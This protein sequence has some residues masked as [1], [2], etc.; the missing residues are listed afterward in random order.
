[1]I[2]TVT[3]NPSVDKFY[4]VEG[5][6]TDR[7][8]RCSHYGKTPGGK[9]LN[10]TRVIHALGESVTATGFL[11]GKNGQF[12]KDR[13]TEAG[14][15]HEFIGI[16]EET[17]ECIAIIDKGKTQT[18]ILESGPMITKREE[19]AFFKRFAQKINAY[20]VITLSGSLP[21]GLDE[22]A[23]QRL[24]RICHLKHKRVLLDSSSKAFQQ[25]L[26]EKPFMIKPNLEELQ[27][28]V[29]KQLL[30]RDLVFEE[31]D[32]LYRSGIENVLIS[33]G[34]E[35]AIMVNKDGFFSLQLPEVSVVNPV[36]SGDSMIA[37]YAAA[38]IR[39]YSSE[40]SLKLAAACGTANAMEAQTG[41]IHMET[42]D[43][44]MK[45]IKIIKH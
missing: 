43:W 7:V 22:A 5:F 36:G 8:F 40:D 31:A 24:I 45:R 17:R 27:G 3:L 12:I 38:L 11:G 1:M 37:G 10:V 9:G 19:D 16:Q 20:D 15:T 18:E 44:L 34:K 4:D 6:T 33:M 26:E 2:L 30:Y 35:G 13:L 21:R 28:L 25:G 29:Q 23:Y 39:G 32:K 42:V 41:Y 14:I